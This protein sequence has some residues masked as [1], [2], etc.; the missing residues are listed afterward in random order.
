MPGHGAG[1]GLADEAGAAR[2]LASAALLLR[3]V[4]TRAP[5]R[6]PG[7]CAGERRRAGAPSLS[8]ALAPPPSPLRPS[9]ALCRARA[10]SSTATRTSSAFSCSR[11][12]RTRVSRRGAGARAAARRQAWR[13]SRPPSASSAPLRCSRAHLLRR[14]DDG[15]GEHPRCAGIC[16]RG[17]ALCRRRCRRHFLPRYSCLPPSCPQASSTCARCR[18]CARA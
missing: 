6:P 4:D 12:C 17:H 14:E 13:G 7:R 18:R 11:A 15:R 2:S 10:A 8:H 9:R 1:L 5:A 16:A 3:R